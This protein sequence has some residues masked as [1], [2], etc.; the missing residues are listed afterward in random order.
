MYNVQHG[1]VV[2][3]GHLTATLNEK[4]ARAAGKDGINFI[5]S[6]LRRLGE[7]VGLLIE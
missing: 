7:V 4:C 1:A 3:L 2:C 5:K 6:A